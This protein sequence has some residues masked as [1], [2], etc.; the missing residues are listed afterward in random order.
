MIV[1]IARDHRG[2][3]LDKIVHAQH[4][5]FLCRVFWFLRSFSRP[6]QTLFYHNPANKLQFGS[7]FCQAQSVIFYLLHDY[8]QNNTN[9]R[10]SVH[11]PCRPKWMWE[12]SV[13]L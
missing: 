8:E 4:L 11:V 5:S 6:L 1:I 2:K 13:D 9:N 7:Q 10:K 12:N 3:S